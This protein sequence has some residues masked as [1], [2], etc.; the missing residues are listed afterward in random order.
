MGW[1]SNNSF[2]NDSLIMSKFYIPC[3]QI[4]ST[5]FQ[6]GFLRNLVGHIN[7]FDIFLTMEL[8]VSGIFVYK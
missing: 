4:I 7:I 6:I 3:I 2:L 8:H 1:Q 5:H